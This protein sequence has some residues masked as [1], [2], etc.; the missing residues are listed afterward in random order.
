MTEFKGY[1]LNNVEFLRQYREHRCFSIINRGLLWYNTL[2]E[3]QL[4]ELD[5]WYKAW[6][7]V[8]TTKIIP[9]EPVWLR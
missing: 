2:S 8:T 1:D 5:V 6:L 7:Q 4:L 9:Q 3:E